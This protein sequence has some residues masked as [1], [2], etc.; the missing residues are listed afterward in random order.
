MENLYLIELKDKN[1]LFFKIGTTVHRYCRFYELMKPGYQIKIIYMIFGIEF[2]EA[3][4]AENK[5]QSVFKPYIPLKKFGGYRECFYPFD[6]NIYKNILNNL[7]TS[8]T[9]IA[10]NIE[11]TWH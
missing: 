4:N 7:I 1:E 8:H 9:E 5:L 11:I 3:L 6:I 10:Q 2:Y